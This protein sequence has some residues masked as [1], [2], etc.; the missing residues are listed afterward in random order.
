MFCMPHL[1]KHCDPSKLVMF[2]LQGFEEDM[3]RRSADYLQVA[4]SAKRIRSA[5]AGRVRPG[6][7]S[8]QMASTRKMLHAGKSAAPDVT[9]DAVEADRD[10]LLHGTLLEAELL[11]QL[12]EATLT[13]TFSHPM[14]R[15]HAHGARSLPRQELPPPPNCRCSQ[16]LHFANRN[17]AR[18]V[19]LW[20]TLW[21]R[22]FEHT[23]LS[24]RPSPLLR[25][26]SSRRLLTALLVM[27]EYIS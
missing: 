7:S 3:L 21:K 24:V 14:H 4:Q 15:S 12:A 2:L 10:L 23:W 16:C 22:A 18:L 8:L 9:P 26:Y 25:R 11:T 6:R 27:Y 1:H 19:D 20:A 5:S 13:N 17:V